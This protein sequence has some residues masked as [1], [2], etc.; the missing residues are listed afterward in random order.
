MNIIFALQESLE[1]SDF[2][3]GAMN[4]FVVPSIAQKELAERLGEAHHFTN[5]D[6]A[7]NGRGKISAGQAR[8]LIWMGAQPFLRAVAGASLLLACLAGVYTLI[9]R[10]S[11]VRAIIYIALGTATM[12]LASTVARIGRLCADFWKGEVSEVSGRLSPTQEIRG[13]ALVNSRETG[14]RSKAAYRYSVAG[15][16]FDIDDQVYRLLADHFELGYPQVTIYYTP[17]TRQ[18]LSLKILGMEQTALH[19][20]QHVKKREVSAPK[21]I[22]KS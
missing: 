2:T 4:G 18:I 14:S 6:L 20:S 11:S 13:Q 21:S 19:A 15:E 7:E 12:G 8:R 3:R 9:S 16:E 17:V 22:W 1:P 5:A 10:Q